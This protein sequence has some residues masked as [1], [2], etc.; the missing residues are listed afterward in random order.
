MYIPPQILELNKLF[1]EN[2]HKLYVVGGAV[3]DYMLGKEPK[4]YD[5]AT[6]AQ[7][8]RV[9][10]ICR[11]Y[12]LIDVGK[13]R[14][15]G[16][17]VIVIDDEPFE[18]ATFREDIGCGRRPEGVVFT[19]IVTD[20]KRR[21]FTI[22]ALFYDIESGE[23][24]DFVGGIQDME[25]EVID[26]VGDPALRFTEDPLRRLR[27]VRFCGYTGFE[28]SDRVYMSLF[29]NNSLDGV[30]DERIRQEFKK[31]ITKSLT[32]ISSLVH[33]KA[34][35]MFGYI[36]GN[37]MYDNRFKDSN[38]WIP[39]LAFMLRDN[40]SEYIKKELHA[41]KYTTDEIESVLFL[42]S[43]LSL[44]DD[45]AYQIK[46]SQKKICISDEEIRIFGGWCGINNELLEKFLSY[47]LTVK[48]GDVIE[49]YGVSGKDIGNLIEDLEIEIFK[50]L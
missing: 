28:L 36:F 23:I 34:F 15:L 45:T 22:N 17:T 6:D 16:V 33:L 47:S 10:E 39:Q 43:L 37:L 9:M 8:S 40:V 49:K 20:V 2:G 48:G 19:D 30:S 26:T 12:R 50:N 11:D 24:C 4:D 29:D 3:R 1:T 35:D 27:A 42:K 38:L 13:S 32:P 46:K 18:I 25:H 21:D 5:V 14:D 7:P 41:K 44:S 31:I